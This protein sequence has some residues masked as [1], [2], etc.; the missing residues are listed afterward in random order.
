MSAALRQML[1]LILDL[2]DRGD[3][4]NTVL[5]FRAKDG[6]LLTSHQWSKSHAR[7]GSVCVAC[8]LYRKR[9]GLA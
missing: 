3:G 5:Q 7:P 8:R 9:P 2:F 1:L 4:R 6:C